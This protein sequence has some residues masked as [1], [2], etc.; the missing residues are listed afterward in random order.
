MPALNILITGASGGIGAATALHF[1]SPTYPQTSGH[2]IHG[3]ALHYS[4]NKAKAEA[5]KSQIHSLNA[6][7]NVQLFH[8]DL[9]Q[10]ENVSRLHSDV[11][12]AFSSPINV[13]FANAGTSSGT[14]IGPQG[15]IGMYNP[16]VIS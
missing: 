13:L 8:A 11:V 5:V 14:S 15:S 9:S 12:S 3:L 1:A 7:L 10:S 6:S 2:T 16:G 4:S